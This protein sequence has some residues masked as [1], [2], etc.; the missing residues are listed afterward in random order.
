MYILLVIHMEYVCSFPLGGYEA[1]LL[2]FSKAYLSSLELYIFSS[3]V[4]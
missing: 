1:S 4:H 2:F 3:W